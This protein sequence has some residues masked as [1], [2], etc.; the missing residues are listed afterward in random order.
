LRERS[1]QR[2]VCHIGEALWFSS[3][4][5][6]SRPQ[7]R[8]SSGWGYHF[9]PFALQ[10][11]HPERQTFLV[12]RSK[13]ARTQRAKE[14]LPRKLECSVA[15]RKLGVKPESEANADEHCPA[16]AQREHLKQDLSISIPKNAVCFIKKCTRIKNNILEI[17]EGLR[18]EG[19]VPYEKFILFKQ[20]YKY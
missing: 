14:N 12:L 4:G 9:L 7:T 10:Q 18:D 5:S 17:A 2:K 16:E 1:A 20:L 13:I 6:W 3:K 15:Q 19:T 8:N 11:P